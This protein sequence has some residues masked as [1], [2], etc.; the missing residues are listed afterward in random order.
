MTESDTITGQIL[1]CFN[2]IIDYATQLKTNSIDGKE[3]AQLV[4]SGF[5]KLKN[6]KKYHKLKDEKIYKQLIKI[7]STYNDCNGQNIDLVEKIINRLN[8]LREYGCELNRIN[9]I[10]DYQWTTKYKLDMKYRYLSNNFKNQNG[11]ENWE[12]YIKMTHDKL[13]DEYNKYNKRMQST[14]TQM[15]T[16][17]IRL[18]KLS[19]KSDRRCFVKT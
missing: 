8:S 17:Q 9:I 2:E 1:V 18:K 12:K 14:I 7:M 15:N 16:H 19:E 10:T 4:A 5:G 13:I 11:H 3:V 6:T